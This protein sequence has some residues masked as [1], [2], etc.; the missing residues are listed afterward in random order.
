[1]SG[2]NIKYFLFLLGFRTKS[3][4][5]DMQGILSK[6]F[7]EKDLREKL[8]KLYKDYSFRSEIKKIAN[9]SIVCAKVRC[10]E[11]NNETSYKHWYAYQEI[12]G[13]VVSWELR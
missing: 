10:G 1:M 11:A 8:S 6:N 3:E 9:V 5:S 13:E 7:I 4:L 2:H 12:S